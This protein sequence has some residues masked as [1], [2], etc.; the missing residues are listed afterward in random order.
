MEIG[1]A[2]AQTVVV[3]GAAVLVVFVFGKL[4]LPAVVG[5]ILTGMLIGPSGLQLIGDVEQ[6]EVFAE[7]GVVLL[8][9]IIGLELSFREIKGL[10]RVF[11]VGGPAQIALTASVVFGLALLAGLGWRAALFTG[12]VVAQTSTAVMLKLYDQRRETHTPHA[13]VAFAVSLFQDLMIVPLIVLTPVVAGVAV[14]SPVELVARF[15]GALVAVGL[16][17]AAARTLMPKV[18]HQLVLVRARELF[19]LAALFVCLAMAW[20]T[21]TLGFS[22]ALGAFLAGLL[23]SETEYS[24]QVVADIVPFRDVFASLFFISIGMLVDLGV[25]FE[26][27]PTLIGLALLLVAIKAAAGVAAV[28]MVGYPVRI[29]VLAGLATA[30]IGEFSFVLMEVGRAHG[31]LAG[32]LYQTLL[33]AAVLTLMVYPLLMRWAPGLGERAAGWLG[34]PP[35]EGVEEVAERLSGHVVVVG[36]GMNGSLLCRVLAAARIPYV[37][38]ELHPAT[39]RAARRQG[40]PIV[41]GDASRREILE[42]AGIERAQVVVFAISDLAAVRNGVRLAKTLNPHVETIVRTRMVRE[43]DELRAAGADDIVAEEFEAAIEIFTR[44]LERYHV[45]RNVIRAQTRVLR[46]ESYRMLRVADPATRASEAVLEALQQGTTELYQ[47]G[48]ESLAA[49]RTLADLHLRRRTG[50]SVIAVVRGERSYPNPSPEIDLENG[51]VLVLVGNHRQIDRAFAYLDREEGPAES[52]AAEDAQA[53]GGA[54]GDDNGAG[55]AEGRFR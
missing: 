37:V 13:R 23:V 43:I 15:F 42:H 8:L 41:F 30:Q 45:P 7:I 21:H 18:L 46:G 19:V 28:A 53:A 33:V 2:L 20:F 26:R 16:V 38:L 52:G 11:A 12:F 36:F 29:A 40:V 14:A 50:A 48:A 24:H 44:V 32:G 34:R 9:F 27:L 31:L 49:G 5:L 22:L 51:D 1:P 39:V 55:G 47:V 10:G 6:V 54:P 17:A 4:R 35:G 3:L 25:A